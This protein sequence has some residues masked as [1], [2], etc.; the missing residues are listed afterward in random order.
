MQ[1]VRAP[2]LIGQLVHLH[3][4]GRDGTLSALDPRVLPHLHV[5]P[6]QARR[7]LH[8]YHLRSVLYA[9]D[10]EELAVPPLLPLVEQP[11]LRRL[12]PRLRRQ[13]LLQ[14]PCGVWTHR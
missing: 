4:L 2:H 9:A 12:Q 7:I 6:L 5:S 10:V 8:Q 13:N 14:L 3:G 11:L 1:V